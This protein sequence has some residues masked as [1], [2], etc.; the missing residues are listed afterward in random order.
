MMVEAQLEND[1]MDMGPC[2]TQL[3]LCHQMEVG[4]VIIKST[5]VEFL[6]MKMWKMGKEPRIVV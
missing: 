1:E 2:S 3:M 5:R 6:T 4:T